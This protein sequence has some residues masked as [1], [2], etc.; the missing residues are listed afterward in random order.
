MGVPIFYWKQP[1]QMRM[2]SKEE[3]ADLAGNVEDMVHIIHELA[4]RL[5]EVIQKN[6]ELEGKVTSLE[7]EVLR[8]E[9][10]VVARFQGFANKANS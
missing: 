5:E 4:R 2:A 3:V 8:H 7:A 1:E 6:A 9:E 10:Y